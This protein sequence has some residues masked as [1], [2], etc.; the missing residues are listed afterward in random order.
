MQVRDG[1]LPEAL[2]EPAHAAW[3]YFMRRGRAA[4]K[5]IA[6]RL[7][8]PAARLIELLEGNDLPDYKSSSLLRCFRY[9][10]MLL[11]SG[12][13]CVHTCCPQGCLRYLH[14]KVFRVHNGSPGGSA[15]IGGSP[16]QCHPCLFSQGPGAA[17][18]YSHCPMETWGCSPSAGRVCLAWS[19]M[20]LSWQASAGFPPLQEVSTLPTCLVH[21]CRAASS[22]RDLWKH[23]PVACL[24]MKRDLIRPKNFAARLAC[25]ASDAQSVLLSRLLLQASSQYW[26]VRRWRW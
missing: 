9:P 20:H 3:R 5:Q 6:A 26:L 17:V 11:H 21:T 10:G 24:L 15:G 13:E 4:L 14:L 19:S 18:K 23:R 8:L 16:V 1:N 12:H 25:C 7:G 2:R 22:A